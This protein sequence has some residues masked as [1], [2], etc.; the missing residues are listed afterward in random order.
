MLSSG[1][2]TSFSDATTP[3]IDGIFYLVR[4][5]GAFCNEFGSWGSDRDQDIP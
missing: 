5:L 1:S 4:E 2:G 3:T